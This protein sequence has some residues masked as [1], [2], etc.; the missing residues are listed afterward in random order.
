MVLC[1]WTAFVVGGS[2][3]AKLSEHFDQAFPGGD[4]T[5]RVA[6][7]AYG[8][9]Q[10]AAGVAGAL[11]VLGAV[12]ALP[13]FVGLLRS[14]GWATVRRHLLAASTCTLVTVGV[15]VP[16]LSWAH[17]LSAHQRN[18]GV[19]AYGL[20]FLVWGVLV[21]LTLVAWT[22]VAVAAARRVVFSRRLLVAEAALAVAVAAAMVVILGSTA[23]WWMVM[24]Q[25]APSFLPS[26]PRLLVTVGLMALASFIAVRGA[27]R[28]SLL[29]TRATSGG[30]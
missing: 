19:A 10:T 24:A 17:H 23:L 14:G 6:D 25:G 30:I 13:S 29:R 28:I 18:G 9:V 8:T 7:V 4:H 5:H 3:F 2:S 15:T 20:L 26:D 21:T 11:V 1:S 16:L 22:T 27:A 12:I